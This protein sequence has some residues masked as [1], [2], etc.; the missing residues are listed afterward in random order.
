MPRGL[1]ISFRLPEEAKL[2]LEEA[3]REHSR[4]LSSLMSKVL[5]DWLKENGHMKG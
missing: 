5:T 4:S 2:A 1:P 3:A